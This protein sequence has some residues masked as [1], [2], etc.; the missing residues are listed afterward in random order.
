MQV[1]RGTFRDLKRGLGLHSLI[2]HMV[3]VS[4]S[5]YCKIVSRET[6]ILVVFRNGT[7]IL[8]EYGELKGAAAME[9][10]YRSDDVNVDVIIHDLNAIQ[11]QLALEFNPSCV[12]PRGVP[13]VERV[14]TPPSVLSE[15][16]IPP[17]FQ[18]LERAREILSDGGGR[19]HLGIPAGIPPATAN[20]PQPVTHTG[21][22]DE[23]SILIQE[24]DALDM[25]EIE[26]MAEKFRASCR[27]MIEKLDLE[28]LLKQNSGDVKNDPN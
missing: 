21:A 23:P 7:I 4:L 27:Q 18:D 22:D 2:S 3:E 19:S 5:G 11:L 17:Q 10:I 13:T 9:Q 15:E 16:V 14:D 28:D 8:A 24:L 12:L 1:P 26:S 25:L 6:P 20:P